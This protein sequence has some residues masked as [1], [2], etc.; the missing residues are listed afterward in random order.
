MEQDRTDMALL[1][2]TAILVIAFALYMIFGP[3]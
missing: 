3:W 1:G 2:V